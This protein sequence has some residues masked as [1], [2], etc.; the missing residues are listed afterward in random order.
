MNL[1]DVLRDKVLRE[2]KSNKL[3][4]ILTTMKK[5]REDRDENTLV[6][7]VS[8]S[9]DAKLTF[10]KKTLSESKKRKKS[11]KMLIMSKTSCSIDHDD[12]LTNIKVFESQKIRDDLRRLVRDYLN[13]ELSLLKMNYQ[14]KKWYV[15]VSLCLDK[16]KIFHSITN[17]VF[18]EH[19]QDFMNDQWVDIECYLNS[20]MSQASFEKI[21]RWMHCW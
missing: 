19:T 8:K 4:A 6:N 9:E 21:Y 17:R 15:S 12:L 10:V 5:K 11:D 20:R 14:S 13:D 18:L 16:F 3:N 2:H 1:N 7:E